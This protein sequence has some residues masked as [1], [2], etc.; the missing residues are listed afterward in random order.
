[1]LIQTLWGA[2]LFIATVLAAPIAKIQKGTDASVLRRM[3]IVVNKNK[4]VPGWLSVPLAY[5]SVSFPRIC[6]ISVTN[7]T[8]LVLKPVS[9]IVTSIHQSSQTGY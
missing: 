7:C 6:I 5:L 9:D 3:F 8:D 4:P 1:M 2:F